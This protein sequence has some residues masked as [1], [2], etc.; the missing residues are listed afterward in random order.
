MIKF[1]EWNE[2]MSNLSSNLVNNYFIIIIATAPL[3]YLIVPLLYVHSTYGGF[4]YTTTLEKMVNAPNT[5]FTIYW[6][7]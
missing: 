7:V 4:Y 6:I 3:W 2:H 1:N 5:V